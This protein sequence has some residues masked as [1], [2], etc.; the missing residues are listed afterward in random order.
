MRQLLE[1]REDRINTKEIMVIMVHSVFLTLGFQ[2]KTPEPKGE[3]RKRD[4]ERE[5]K[6]KITILTKCFMKT[7][8]LQS[9]TNLD[10]V[11]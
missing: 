9:F 1:M 7:K 4:N 6:F 2:L 8:D 5:K 3:K 10:I 11:G